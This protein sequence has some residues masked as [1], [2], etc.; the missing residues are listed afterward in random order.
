[1]QLV[2]QDEVPV[3]VVGRKQQTSPALQSADFAQRSVAVKSPDCVH[4]GPHVRSLMVI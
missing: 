4:V 2:S 3:F 1:L